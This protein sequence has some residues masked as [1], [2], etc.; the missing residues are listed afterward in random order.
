VYAPCCSSPRSL[1]KTKDAHAPG[2]SRATDTAEPRRIERVTWGLNNR[3]AE[4]TD[5]AETSSA[6]IH[7]HQYATQ[8]SRRKLGTSGTRSG[9]GW[10]A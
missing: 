4:Q 9:L 8:G 5:A 10:I 2:V 6:P 3:G 7:R 1:T